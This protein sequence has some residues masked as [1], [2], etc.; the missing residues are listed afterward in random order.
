MQVS[1][2]LVAEGSI[3][4]QPLNVVLWDDGEEG[5]K[6]EASRHVANLGKAG[7]T[8]FTLYNVERNGLKQ[9]DTQVATFRIG[10]QEPQIIME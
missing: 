5:A 8:R 9:A 1:Y 2:I 7:Y 10:Y 6:I 3:N 4:M